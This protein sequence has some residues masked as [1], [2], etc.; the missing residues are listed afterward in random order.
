MERK[1]FKNKASLLRDFIFA[2][3][4]GLVTTFAI[5]S[6]TVG[7]GLGA[8]AAIALGLANVLAD[9]FSLGTGIYMGIKSEIDASVGGDVKRIEGSPFVHSLVS[10]FSFAFFG[11]LMTI[12]F[13][14]KL[15]SAYSYSVVGFVFALLVI[16]IVKAF[17]TNKNIIKSA[18]EMLLIGGLSSLV[19]FL[20]GF[21]TD[22]L[23]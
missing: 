8:K 20:V 1:Y 3:D 2:A 13:I 4:D 23:V 16:G 7:A 22:K 14:L 21:F 9:G 15:D 17:F 19:A 18:V 12:P 5:I 6:G 10:F 11:L